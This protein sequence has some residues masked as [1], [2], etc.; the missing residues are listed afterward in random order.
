MS[1]NTTS[2]NGQF[3]RVSN[4]HNVDWNSDIPKASFTLT[5]LVGD[6]TL[7]G[8]QMRDNILK[9]WI[10]PKDGKESWWI[11]GKQEKSAKPWTDQSGKVHNYSAINS[12]HPKHMSK[13]LIAQLTDFIKGLYREDGN[14]EDLNNP[15]PEA[16]TATTTTGTTV[17]NG[18]N[19]ATTVTATAAEPALAK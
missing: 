6:G 14:Y 11:E 15:Q 10:N 13:D 18:A 19:A 3:F 17:A 7:G 8:P 9:C 2:Q 12:F 5:V 1:T 16:T 4:F